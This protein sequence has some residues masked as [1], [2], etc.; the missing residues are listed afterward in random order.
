MLIELR[1]GNYL[2]TE[3]QNQNHRGDW[4]RLLRKITSNYP[5]DHGHDEHF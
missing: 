1:N 2:N 3:I 4:H 5:H